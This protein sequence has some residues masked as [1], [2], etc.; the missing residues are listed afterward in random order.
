MKAKAVVI[1]FD[2]T[3]TTEDMSDLLA[4]TVGKQVESMELNRQFGRETS[5]V[6]L[7]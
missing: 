5:P 4:K 1:D 3:I 2:G 7:G 6:Y